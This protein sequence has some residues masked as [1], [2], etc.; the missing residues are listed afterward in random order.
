MITDVP[1]PIEGLTDDERVKFDFHGG[2]FHRQGKTQH[3]NVP[4]GAKGSKWTLVDDESPKGKGFHAIDLLCEAEN[5]E[6]FFVCQTGAS[7]SIMDENGNE[8]HDRI[9]S[10]ENV[11]GRV[12][13][14]KF[15]PDDPEYVELE[16][17]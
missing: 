17:V 12:V 5:G 14:I 1:D 10:V 15:G 2:N 8:I 6:K 7:L 16:S 3:G 4:L 11:D 9:R 13:K